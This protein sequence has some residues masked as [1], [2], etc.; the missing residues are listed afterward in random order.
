MVDKPLRP[1]VTATQGCGAAPEHTQIWKRAWP[2]LKRLNT[3]Y[4][5]GRG[6]AQDYAVALSWFRRAAEQGYAPGQAAT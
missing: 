6:V 1:A 4:E 2:L 3:W 5:H